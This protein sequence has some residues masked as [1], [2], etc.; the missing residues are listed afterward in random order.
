MDNNSF[1]SKVYM[2]MFAGVLVSFLTAYVVSINPNMLETIFSGV[3]FIVC[4][5][6]ELVVALVFSFT[7]KKMKPTVAKMLFLVYS[8]VTGLTFSSI[9]VVYELNSILIIFGLTSLLF[10]ILSLMGKNTKR[11]LT[12][13]GNILLI[14]LIMI[15]IGSLVN[16]F[17][18]N[19]MLDLILTIVGLGIFIGLTAYDTQKI[20]VLHSA[21]VLPEEN[22]AVYGAFE[23]YLD[24]I[25]IFLRLIELFG[26]KND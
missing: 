2:W 6:T 16:L 11:D 1:L 19:S 4:I 12:S 9:F 3:G 13:V 24:F 17:L 22:L 23:L 8:F 26:N 5:V 15:I 10:L 14:G 18:N 25:N 20:L 21:S 7:I